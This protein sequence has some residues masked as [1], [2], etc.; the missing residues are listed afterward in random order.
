[1]GMK[2][3]FKREDASVAQLVEQRFCKP[4][5]AGSIPVAGFETEVSVQLSDVRTDHRTLITDN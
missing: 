5:V 4:P 2:M 3:S 1:M